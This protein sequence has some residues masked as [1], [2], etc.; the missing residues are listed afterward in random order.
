MAKQREKM[1]AGRAGGRNG[2]P[3]ASTGKEPVAGQALIVRQM[4]MTQ[5]PA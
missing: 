3:V 4:K 2:L 5:K 1:P